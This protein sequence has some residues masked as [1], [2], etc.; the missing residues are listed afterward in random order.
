MKWPPRRFL[1]HQVPPGLLLDQL[2]AVSILNQHLHD[3]LFKHNPQASNPTFMMKSIKPVN[4]SARTKR[5]APRKSTSQ[6]A[7]NSPSTPQPSPHTQAPS[8]VSGNTQPSETPVRRRKSSATISQTTPTTIQIACHSC[9]QTDVPLMMGGRTYLP[10]SLGVMTHFYVYLY[11]GFCRPCIDS[12]KAKP[13]IPTATRTTDRAA[14]K[15]GRRGSALTAPTLVAHSPLAT[16]PPVVFAPVQT[17]Q[18]I[19]QNNGQR[20]T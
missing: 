11:I 7:S 8:P 19:S 9:G 4:D 14:T 18:N 15:T 12:G 6:A 20:N 5:R 17:P 13:D 1:Q 16:N 3:H 10:C 2:K